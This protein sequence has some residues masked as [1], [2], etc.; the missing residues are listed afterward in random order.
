[1]TDDIPSAEMREFY[2][3][4]RAE[5]PIARAVPGESRLD[6]SELVRWL[7]GTLDDAESAAIDG[8]ILADPSLLETMLAARRGVSVVE[9][10]S[11]AFVARAQALGARPTSSNIPT[12][13]VLPFQTPSRSAARGIG[14]YLAWGAVAA[15]LALVSVTGFN[16]GLSLGG[17][18]AA[19]HPGHGGSIAADDGG[20]ASV[21]SIGDGIG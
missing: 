14:S 19:P 6:P 21:G 11:A 16:L 1:M 5:F 7:D 13:P 15:S 17:R 12:E 18:F 4:L 20:D 3:R 9:T 2:R 8:A 10:P